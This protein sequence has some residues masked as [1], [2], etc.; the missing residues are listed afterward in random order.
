MQKTHGFTL[1]ELL[2][3]IA[4][5]SVLTVLAIPSLQQMI[6]RNQITTTTNDLVASLLLARSAAVTQEQN[7]EVARLSSWNKGWKVTNSSN[8]VILRHNATSSSLNISSVGANL[9]NSF[10]YTA[11]GRTLTALIP[12][13]DYFKV[14]IGDYE[15][16]VNFSA[17][18]RPSTGDCP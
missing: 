10:T 15:R 7:V 9:G 1:L 6:E 3:T 8:T 5:L 16:C 14:S 11:Q 4:I 18:G 12:G 17:S 2:L 13:T